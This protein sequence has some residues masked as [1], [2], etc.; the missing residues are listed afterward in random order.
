[1]HDHPARTHGD[2]G[3]QRLHRRGRGPRE[4]A[5]RVANCVWGVACVCV[6]GGGGHARA[7]AW[8]CGCAGVSIFLHALLTTALWH[9]ASM[10]ST[11]RL[12][13]LTRH[14]RCVGVGAAHPA[15]AC[16]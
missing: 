13:A 5:S 11:R 15:T 6:G 3:G 7:R 12:Q 9:G 4:R 8:W 10:H 16:Q 1:V 2:G 14:A